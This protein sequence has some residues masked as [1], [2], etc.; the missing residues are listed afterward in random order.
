MTRGPMTPSQ[1]KHYAEG[2]CRRRHVP[3][4]QVDDMI[5]EALL[6][7]VEYGG[8]KAMIARAVDRCAHRETR[9]R[10]RMAL[11]GLGI[12]Q[13]TPSTDRRTDLFRPSG[14]RHRP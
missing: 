5:G 8:D 7:Q 13:V 6:A 12:G 11:A 3:V 14:R 9:R 1:A 10:A 2:Y 4:D